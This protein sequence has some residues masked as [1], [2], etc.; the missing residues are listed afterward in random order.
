MLVNFNF[1]TSSIAMILKL[2]LHNPRLSCYDS[3]ALLLCMVTI[4]I[5]IQ[6]LDQAS[7]ALWGTVGHSYLQIMTVCGDRGPV[8]CCAK[9]W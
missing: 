3:T 6:G 5:I 7:G 8:I 2:D 4:V 9:P 1:A